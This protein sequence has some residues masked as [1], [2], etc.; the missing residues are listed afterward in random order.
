MA[1][2][3]RGTV[4]GFRFFP[5]LRS[6]SQNARKL[7]LTPKME[8]NSRRLLI[9]RDLTPS[10]KCKGR[11]FEPVSNHTFRLPLS[12]LGQN[13]NCYD[14]NRL[15]FGLRPYSAEN[16]EKSKNSRR[17]L[18]STVRTTIKPHFSFKIPKT[19]KSHKIAGKS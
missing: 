18:R 13:M 19:P 3:T 5:C 12:A 2:N 10:G 17:K 4:G 6:R 15:T 16:T 14:K 11:R 8:T 1:I 7:F 9:V